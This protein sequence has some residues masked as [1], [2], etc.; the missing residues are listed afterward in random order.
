MK[1]VSVLGS[2]KEE[3]THGS[4]SE[5][6]QISEK[7]RTTI[8]HIANSLG[9]FESILSSDAA[10][11]QYLNKE[12]DDHGDYEEDHAGTLSGNADIGEGG[13]AEVCVCISDII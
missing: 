4:L 7:H 2:P 9:L 13:I 12:L 8:S 1:R 5:V 11:V 10:F 6:E 3:K